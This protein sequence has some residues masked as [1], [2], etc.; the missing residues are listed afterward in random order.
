MTVGCA[1]AF[2]MRVYGRAELRPAIRAP[3]NVLGQQNKSL[4]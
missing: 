4:S 1:V 3:A 2:P